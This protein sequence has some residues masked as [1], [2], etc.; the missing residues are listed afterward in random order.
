MS[1]RKPLQVKRTLSAG[2]YVNG[3]YLPGDP[4]PTLLTI[5]AS[6]QPATGKVLEA[7]PE[8][9]RNSESYVLY[10]DSELFTAE[11]SGSKNADLVLIFSREF[12]VIKVKKYQNGVISHYEVLFAEVEQ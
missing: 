2:K 4:V 6:V 12:E 1:F 8:G 7:L 9:R 11:V 10:T 3:N 5:F